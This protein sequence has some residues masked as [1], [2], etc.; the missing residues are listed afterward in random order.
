VPRP[1]RAAEREARE[2]LSV[3]LSSIAARTRSCSSRHRSGATMKTRIDQTAGEGRHSAFFQR[4][5][6]Q[7]LDF[8]PFHGFHG[9]HAITSTLK[10]P[11]SD[12]SSI[13][14]SVID[15]D[16]PEPSDYQDQSTFD[17]FLK[18][19]PP[20]TRTSIQI[21]IPTSGDPSLLVP[22]RRPCKY[23]NS[24]GVAKF[25]AQPQIFCSLHFHRITIGART[26]H[27]PTRPRPHA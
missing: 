17:R 8:P 27:D 23:L 7:P 12:R 26:C 3:Q 18:S 19:R 4:L 5:S 6:T 1:G 9:I 11:T 25:P 16:R 13:D 24:R 2:R 22:A 14:R 10:S 15:R 21:R 20:H